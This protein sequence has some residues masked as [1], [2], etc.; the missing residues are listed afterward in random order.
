[1]LTMAYNFVYQQ[2]GNHNPAGIEINNGY[3]ALLECIFQGTHPSVAL[4]RW[5]DLKFSDKKR[6]YKDK[7]VIDLDKLKKIFKER[8]LTYQYL[9]DITGKSRTYFSHMFCTETRYC[10]ADF[11]YM[12]EEGLGLQKGELIKGG[13]GKNAD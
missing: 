9:S 2:F 8:F 7:V 4:L 13:E 5:C 11:I 6:V 3:Y 12:L 10:D 1:M